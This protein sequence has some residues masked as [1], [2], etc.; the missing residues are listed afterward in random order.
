MISSAIFIQLSYVLSGADNSNPLFLIVVSVILG[1]VLGYLMGQLAGVLKARPGRADTS[2]RTSKPW[3]RPDFV[4]VRTVRHGSAG[5][6]GF[7]SA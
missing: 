6:R 2:A 3:V 7:F 1:A 4:A 5:G